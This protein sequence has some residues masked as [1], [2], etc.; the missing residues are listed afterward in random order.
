MTKNWMLVIPNIFFSCILSSCV[1]QTAMTDEKLVA[2]WRGVPLGNKEITSAKQE[3]PNDATLIDMQQ[4]TNLLRREKIT[5]VVVNQAEKYL[6]NAFGTFEDLRDPENFSKA[7]T[8]DS[9]TPY[10]GR[11]FERMLTAMLI[12][13]L[14]ISRERC[15]MALP[16]L[17]A[18]EFLDARWQP[19]MFGS[20]APMVY[21]LM[22][23]CFVETKNTV[24]DFERAKNGLTMS[25]RMQLLLEPFFQKINQYA[26][27]AARDPATQVALALLEVGLPSSLLSAPASANIEEIVRIASAE[28]V[29]FLPRVLSQS[30]APYDAIVRPLLMKIDSKSTDRET[31][32][33]AIVQIE[34]ALKSILK[35]ILSQDQFLLQATKLLDHV[36]ALSNQIEEA[37]KKPVMTV[38][39]DGNGPRIKQEGQYNEIA[40]I[41]PSSPEN[42]RAGVPIK[43]LHV[44][45]SCGVTNHKNNLIFTLCSPGTHPAS[46][47]YASALK[48]WSSSFQATTTAGRKFDRIL[49]GRAQFR[50]GTE[51]AAIIGGY[52]AL[53]LLNASSGIQGKQAHQMQAAALV[54]GAIAGAAWIAGRAS[55]PEADIRQVNYN[56][57]SGYL[58]L[59][60]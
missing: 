36:Y 17:K 14:D 38:Y 40:N 12:A 2:L 60:N 42:V 58:L 54:I 16:A 33:H 9:Q 10:R 13:L 11:P 6:E 45:S 47:K 49:K 35:E 52:T 25:L 37:A 44:S 39:F 22:L 24:Q 57:E 48:L 53:A 7:F 8:I 3:W 5:P 26:S 21:A 50:T 30:E 56:F 23:R 1:H 31:T 55:N 19:F 51:V 20:D 41:I 27:R 28:A 34:I 29:A 4:G 43:S 18:A 46:L 32:A 15:D 59:T